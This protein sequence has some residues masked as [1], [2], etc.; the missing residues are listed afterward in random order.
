MPLLYM[1]VV[2]GVIFVAFY[3]SLAAIR[4][5]SLRPNIE[6]GSYDSCFNLAAAKVLRSQFDNTVTFEQSFVGHSDSTSFAPGYP[7]IKIT[8]SNVTEWLHVVETNGPR[9]NHGKNSSLCDN[10]ETWVFVDVSEE[11]RAKDCPFYASGGTFRDNPAWGILPHKDLYWRGRAFGLVMQDGKLYP[12]LGLEWGF[13]FNR[14]SVKPTPIY[15]RQ[16]NRSD[17]QKLIPSLNRCYQQHQF[18]LRSSD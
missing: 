4:I 8:C 6:S 1:L 11:S 18:C 15:P 14:W 5:I 9:Q 16:L 12:L 2:G 13:R 17:W 10:S 7:A 3:I